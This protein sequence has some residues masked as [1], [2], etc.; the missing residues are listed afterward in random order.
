M[1]M[2]RQ[3]KN[4]NFCP[5][6]QPAVA[7]LLSLF[8]FLATC[9]QVF[10]ADQDDAP[11]IKVL[12]PDDGGIAGDAQPVGQASNG[13][14]SGQQ[15][16]LQ[17]SSTY[18][19]NP[20]DQITVADY[21]AK[22][23]NQQYSSQRITILP[24]GTVSIYPVGVLKASGMSVQD[25][26]KL[27]NEKA[28]P[29]YVQPDFL[30]YVS[31]MRPVIVYVLGD[32][33]YPGVYRLG[34]PPQLQRTPQP[35]ITPD[36]NYIAGPQ[37][38]SNKGFFSNLID[39][40][41]NAAGMTAP[42]G[43]MA[44]PDAFNSISRQPTG[45]IAE[46]SVAPGTLTILSALQRAGGL[47]DSANVRQVRV[48]RQRTHQIFEV[49]LWKLLVE[50][51]TSQ[52]LQ[53]ESGD[54][55]FAPQGGANYDPDSLGRFAGER[56]REVRILGSIKAPGLYNMGPHDDIISI[57]SKAGGFTPNAEKSKVLLSR[58]NRD[59]TITHR[60]IAMS[61]TL[62]DN[63]YIGREPLRPGDVVLVSDNVV[64]AVGVPLSRGLFTVAAALFL[65]WMSNRIRNVNVTNNPTGSNA[66]IAIL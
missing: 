25:F 36:T 10:A 33:L 24:D 45:S 43:A 14:V 26:N 18:I 41:T 7:L 1:P 52:D 55:I 42:P 56:T 28:K 27:L 49:D 60:V 40:F 12:P 15:V 17:N 65:I 11:P 58:V 23:G 39:T 16:I 13:P 35:A 61:A 54:T 6:W 21:S 50:G 44:P 2:T 66:R 53:L 9:P 19:L 51:D 22:E 57:I 5:R 64:R 59:G 32:V 20:G 62:K 30:V 63:N 34:G 38:P 29:F 31:R 37:Q 48:T 4:D 46:I 47:K 8:L 3:S